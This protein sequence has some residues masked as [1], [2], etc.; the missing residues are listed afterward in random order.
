MP[1]V[2]RKSRSVDFNF[3]EQVLTE[4]D[5]IQKEYEEL[6]AGT[7][8]LASGG[9]QRGTVGGSQPQ[10]QPQSD[11]V[12]RQAWLELVAKY[13]D[14]GMSPNQAVSAANRENE[15]LR[16]AMLVERNGH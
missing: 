11:G 9:Y 16:L 6:M 15:G 1:V 2:V 7:A 14:R 8:R 3:A 13:R 12:M 5:S 4:F 10:S